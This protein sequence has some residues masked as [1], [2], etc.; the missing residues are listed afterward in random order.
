MTADADAH[1]E[2]I[3][4]LLSAT[5]LEEV[6][7]LS[8]DVLKDVLEADT[9]AIF[10]WDNDLEHL[11]DKFVAADKNKDFKSLVE[12]FSKDFDGRALW[13]RRRG[14]GHDKGWPRPGSNIWSG[15]LP[16]D[17]EL[18]L[19]KRRSQKFGRCNLCPPSHRRSRAG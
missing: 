17:L 16:E 2:Q 14:T 9:A 19:G 6:M 10:M 3:I 5:E 11:S 12:A 7:E 8:C 18:D 4:A 1:H 15:Q 13:R